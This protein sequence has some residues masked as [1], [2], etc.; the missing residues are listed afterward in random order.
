MVITGS[1]FE[2]NVDYSF[3]DQASI[4]CKAL[5]GFMKHANMDNVEFLQLCK[6]K[7][8]LK[9]FIDN[10]RLYKR[11]IKA[12]NEDDQ[13]WIDGLMEEDDLL[14]LCGNLPD[15]TFTIFTSHEDTPIDEHIDVPSNVTIY[16]LNA[17]HNNEKVIPFPFGLQ[18][19]MT[20][21]DPRLE[22]MEEYLDINYA[23]TKLLYMN[24]GIGRNP[25]R[26]GLE[27]FADCEYAT[28]RIDPNSRF[29]SWDKY[30]FYLNE[31]LDHKF[32]ICP[33]GHGFDCHR[34][35]ETLY[36][37]R[38]PIMK[39]HPYFEKLMKG[40][41]V[42]FVDSY[43]DVNEQLLLD[44]EHLYQEAQKLDLNRWFTETYPALFE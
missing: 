34:N 9:L 5:G 19:Q 27:R 39:R 10:I 8:H 1:L 20:W 40:L 37:R 25:E 42:L 41:P 38:V 2:D 26:Q 13:V 16:A 23:P 22:I 30:R 17:L 3:G 21:D 18:R 33:K 7:K 29:Y 6:E 31:V 36:L 15:N 11:P 28:A 43:D 35:W 14:K 12:D 4:V 44:N 32:V 24:M